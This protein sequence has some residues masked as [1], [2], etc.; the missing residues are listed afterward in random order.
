MKSGVQVFEE[1][2]KIL[3]AVAARYDEG[4][5]EHSALMHATLALLYV[6]TTGKQKFMEHVVAPES[7]LTA[8]QKRSLIEMGIDPDSQPITD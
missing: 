7:G 8:E 5:R 4:S 3:E 2:S 1:D 6:L